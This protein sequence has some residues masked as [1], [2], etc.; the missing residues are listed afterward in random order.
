MVSFITIIT[1]SI[2]K[3]EIDLQRLMKTQPTKKVNLIKEVI[4]SKEVV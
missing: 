2:S 4:M 1:L 3:T